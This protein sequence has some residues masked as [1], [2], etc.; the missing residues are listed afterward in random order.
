MREKKRINSSEGHRMRP[1]KA[2]RRRGRPGDLPKTLKMGARQ[3]GGKKGN[4]LLNMFPERKEA[5][6]EEKGGEAEFQKG[7]LT[8]KNQSITNQVYTL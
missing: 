6:K 5:P 7:R 3:R 4:H 2:K 8:E 1:R